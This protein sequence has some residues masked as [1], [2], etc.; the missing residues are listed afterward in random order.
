MDN[1]IKQYGEDHRYL[2]EVVAREV[3][4]SRRSPWTWTSSTRRW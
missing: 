1:Q 4:F 3:G 2:L